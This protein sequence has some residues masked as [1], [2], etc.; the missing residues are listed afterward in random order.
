MMAW[1]AASCGSVNA[2]AP[3]GVFLT[4][5]CPGN[6]YPGKLTAYEESPE[7]KRGMERFGLES[8]WFRRD[9]IDPKKHRVDPRKCPVNEL[10]YL[11][12]RP[13]PGRKPVPMVLYFGGT[14]EHGTNLVDQFHQTTI[15]AKLTDPKFQARH[16][17]YVFTPMLP[18]DGVIRSALPGNVSALAALINDALYAVAGSL[19]SPPVD[20]NRFYLTGLSYG[21]VVAFELPCA[22]PGRF[23]ASVPV[24]C[25]QSAF[26][27]PKT[28]PGNYWLLYN[29]SAYRTPVAK[30]TLVDLA[31]TVEERGGDFRQSTFPDAGHDAWS[32]A[33]R[34]DRVWDWMFGKTADGKPVAAG[35]AAGPRSVAPRQSSGALLDGVV[36]TASQPGADAGRGPERAADNLEATCYVSA[37][38]MKRGDWW[39]IEFPKPVTGQIA[40]HSGTRDGADRLSAGRVEVSRDGRFWN[41][42]APFSR[43]TGACA[44]IQRSP[45]RHLRVL[46]E[47]AKPEVLTLREIGVE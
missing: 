28:Q 33:W 29:E 25:F 42:A 12:Y 8:G 24:S 45:I 22:F 36:C 7:L 14:G 1:M 41:R 32:K 26:M 31:R 43:A 30:Q 6:G 10:P 21:G 3:S 17:C 9:A 23:A 27:I 20:T 2:A 39:M 5:V 46:P 19:K 13:E 47:P 37:E 18:K 44:F 4:G 38:P 40:V 15:F 35:P 34:E 11:L 16:P